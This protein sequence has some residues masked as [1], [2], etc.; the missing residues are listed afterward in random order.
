VGCEQ[1][2]TRSDRRLG[3][4]LHYRVEHAMREA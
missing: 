4:V 3:A 2:A 1:P